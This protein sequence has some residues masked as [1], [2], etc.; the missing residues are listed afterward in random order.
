MLNDDV[1]GDY[2]AIRC[3][4]LDGNFYFTRLKD[5]TGNRGAIKCT[6]FNKAWYI[7]CEFESK[8]GKAKARYWKKSITRQGK[9]LLSVLPHLCADW[10]VPS[11]QDSGA[12][13]VPARS[14]F[15]RNPILA[16]VKAHRLR[17]DNDT[18][19]SSL[20]EIFDCSSL[21]SALREL[22]E[23]CRSDLE[24]I[25]FLYQAHRSTDTFFSDLDSAFVK[26]DLDNNLPDIFCEASDLLLLPSPVGS[27]I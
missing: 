24:R 13:N 14:T 9:Q 1:E 26:L 17:G 7:P 15:L 16:F 3:G 27:S 25:G 21:S 4:S 6:L 5:R 2:I 18:L 10:T 22:W 19:R 20:L 23:F 12:S 11:S 8:G